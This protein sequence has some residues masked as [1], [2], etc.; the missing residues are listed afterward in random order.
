[1]K[2]LIIQSFVGSGTWWSDPENLDK[3][4]NDILIPSVGRY[5]ERYKYKHA[6]YKDQYDLLDIVNLKSNSTFGNLYHQYL[7]ALRHKDEDVDYIVFMDSDFY[8]TNNAR[9]LVQTSWIK[10]NVWSEEQIKLWSK[11]KDPK[12]FRAVMGGIQ[13][14]RK[15]AAM[16]LATYMKSRLLDYVIKDSPITLMPDEVT[17]GEWLVEYNIEPEKLSQYYNWILDDVEDREWSKE[18]KDAGFW[19]FVGKNKSEKLAYVLEHIDGL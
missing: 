17:L 14:L 9:A 15:E 12:T 8:V 10:G 16:S 2:Y 3:L 5:C 6:V 4:Y 1:M 11:G 19:H 13:V 18:D 7:S